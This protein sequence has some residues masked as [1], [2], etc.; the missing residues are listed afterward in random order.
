MPVVRPRAVEPVPAGACL[1]A[2]DEMCT[3]RRHLPEEL[4]EVPLSRPDVAEGD[5][6]GV[7]FFGDIGDRNGVFRD[8]QTD[9][10]C[11]RL[12]HD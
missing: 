1:I 6:L 12:L 3:W 4:S 8:I 10:E 5:D 11:A 2:K 9:V 7:V